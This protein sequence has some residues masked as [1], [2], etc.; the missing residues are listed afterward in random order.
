MIIS[1]LF[2]FIKEAQT[3]QLC[4]Q[5]LQVHFFVEGLF[6]GHSFYLKKP[7]CFMPSVMLQRLMCAFSLTFHLNSRAVLHKA[8][9]F[10]GRISVNKI[11]A[12]WL[13]PVHL[14]MTSTVLFVVAFHCAFSNSWAW[15]C[16]GSVCLCA[17]ECVCNWGLKLGIIKMVVNNL[18]MAN[19]W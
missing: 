2:C 12:C 19:H 14:S 4:Q 5:A 16:K 10:T 3:V 8:G 9:A 15:L 1:I 17:C 7:S 13:F 6:R 11:L 18:L